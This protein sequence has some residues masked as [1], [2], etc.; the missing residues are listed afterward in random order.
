MNIT[1]ATFIQK[2]IEEHIKDFEKHYPDVE[3]IVC[4]ACGS[5]NYNLWDEKSDVDTKIIVFPSFENLV[6]GEAGLSKTHILPNGEH[7]DIKDVRHYFRILKKANINF[8]ELLCTTYYVVNP[9]YR[10]FWFSITSH[11]PPLSYLYAEK[12]V[13]SSYGMAQEKYKKL[14]HD[15]PA[16]HELIKQ[17]GYV[18]KELVNI[19]RLRY[20]IEKFMVERVGFKASIEIFEEPFHAEL[21]HLKR[22]RKIL[23]P[24]EVEKEARRE[25]TRMWWCIVNYTMPDIEFYNRFWDEPFTEDFLNKQ[26]I[27]VMKQYLKEKIN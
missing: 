11:L 13:Y 27:N 18:A 7:C 19:K 16:N 25:L 4:G 24:G 10:N 2:R 20:F 15:S 23:T 8:M 14:F 17:Y 12:L 1:D 9:K 22:Y 26:L 6:L 5:M 3:W 21:M